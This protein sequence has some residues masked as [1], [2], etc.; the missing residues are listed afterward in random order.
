[1]EKHRKRRGV[2]MWSLWNDAPFHWGVQGG[3]VVRRY[4]LAVVN[5]FLQALFKA[6]KAAD[7]S[8]PITAAN[9]LN[10]PGYDVGFAFLD[11]IGLNVYA[12]VSDWVSGSFDPALG[13]KTIARVVA[14]AEKHKKPVYISEIGQ[15]DFAPVAAQAEVIPAQLALIGNRLAGFCLFQWQDNWAKAG[16]N[17]RQSHDI[18]THWGIV[19]ARR[20]PKAGFAAV[21]A[22]VKAAPRGAGELVEGFE[23]ADTAALLAQYSVRKK[24]NCTYRPT[25]ES[26]A[27]GGKHL[28]ISFMP[29][30]FGAWLYVAR[31][32]SAERDWSK[33]RWL[34]F[35]MKSQGPWV[36]L[37]PLVLTADGAVWRGPAL[38][39]QND[40]WQTF[41]I[42]LRALFHD[43][44]F[45][46]TLGGSSEAL[47]PDLRRVSGLGV[48]VNDVANFEQPGQ[49]T[50]LRLDDFLLE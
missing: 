48:K 19:D 32:F 45:E 49:G 13:Q 9:V 41:R 47:A 4:G 38:V 12:G 8:R 3:N 21:V 15:S 2:L 22:A 26:D 44:G 25:L 37:S 39:T 33:A 29:E 40:E 14:I 6:V 24:G 17:T 35:A 36:N 42:D 46:K 11:V 28:L 50:T 31:P 7:P 27:R 34:H 16:D 10:A 5:D 23:V 20:L 1:V 18:E 43:Y 30:D